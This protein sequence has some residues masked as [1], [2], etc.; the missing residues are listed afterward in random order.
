MTT[1]DENTGLKPTSATTPD[2]PVVDASADITGLDKRSEDGDDSNLSL[3]KSKSTV[4]MGDDAVV[5]LPLTAEPTAEPPIEGR[6][7]ATEQ[8][9]LGRGCERRCR[10]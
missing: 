8:V 2:P 6:G 1:Q 3:S 7:G 9:Q 5:E 4:S 10:R